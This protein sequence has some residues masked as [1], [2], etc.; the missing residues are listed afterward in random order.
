M[1]LMLIWGSQDGVFGKEAY[2]K[3]ASVVSESLSNIRT[4][5]SLNAETTMSKKYDKQLK[6]SE[7]A[8]VRQSARATSVM[9]LVLAI[10]FVMYGLGFW[11]GAELIAKSTDTALE[12][13][14]S[15]PGLFD[16]SS[17]QYAE[18]RTYI[19]A[20]CAGYSGDALEVCAC[21][22]PYAAL[23]LENPNCGCGFGNGG[24]AKFS[25][26]EGC[27]SGGKTMM[28][29]FAILIGGFSLGQIGPGIKALGDARIAAAKMVAVI[30]RR[31][32]ID[33]E[34]TEGKKRL[35]RGSVAG[36]ITLEDLHFWYAD[37]DG[38]ERRVFGGCNLTIKAGETVALV[39]ESGC[40]KSTI[41]KL[42]QRFYDPTGGRILL[43][44]TD[45]REL[46]LRDLRSSIG[47]VSQE[48]LLF[49][50][51][52]RDNIRCGLPGASD[53]DI[54]AAAKNANAHGFISSFPDGYD[55]PVGPGGN[56]L[57]GGQKQRVAIAR[58]LLRD[59]TILILDE[60]T[61]ALDNKSE[62]IVQQ[63]LDQLVKNNQRQRTTIVIA[64][65][66]STIR[67]ADKIVVVGSPN[68]TSTTSGGSIILEQGTHDDLMAQKGFYKAL[69]GATDR[70]KDAPNDINKMESINLDVKEKENKEIPTKQLTLKKQDK[71]KTKKT[72]AEIAEKQLEKKRAKDNKSR[73]WEYTWPE[74]PLIVL[75]S[76]VSVCKGTTM[77]LLS[78]IMSEMIITWYN[79]DTQEMRNVSKNWSF[80]FYGFAVLTGIFE[81]VQKYVFERVG[82]RLTTKLRS[83]LFRSI[84][85]QD[86]T[87]FEDKANGVGAL[88]S[89]L[90]MDVKLVRLVVGQQ[91]AASLESFS[92]LATGIIIS[93]IATW[94]VFLIMLAMVPLLG[95]TEM[96]QWMALQGSEGNIRNEMMKSTAILHET[97]NGIR[98]VQAFGLES[99]IA[100][101]IKT[102]LFETIGPAS[103]TASV[104]KGTMMGAVQAIQFLVYAFA[105]WFGGE[106]IANGR[107]SFE[108]FTKALWAMAFAASGLGAA[109]TFAGD[110]AK[111][112]AAVKAIFDTLDHDSEIKSE[113]WE[114]RGLADSQSGTAIVRSLPE[115]TLI[116]G[117]SE[118]ASV[119]FCYPTR[120]GAKI[121]DRLSLSIPSG[122]V[123]ALVGS[124]GSGKSTV[125]QLLERF[126]D[127]TSY[128]EEKEDGENKMVV[129]REN[130]VLNVDGVDVKT[131][132]LR[133]LRKN[134]ALVGQEPV[135]FND[136][137]YNNIALG[138][139][140]CTSEEVLTA[141]RRAN[142]HNFIVE[143]Q[144]G[145][146]TIVGNAGGL[147]SGGQKQ[148]IAIARALVN[149]PKILLLDEATSAL[150]NE[151]EKIV[152]A[153][154]D[155]LVKES[156]NGGRTTIIIAHRLST[157]RNADVICVLENNGDGSRV[158]ETGSHNEL[159]M[160]NQKYTALVEA[161]EK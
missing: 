124:S 69:L 6:Q 156:E 71:Q 127:P 109:A 128:K 23:G 43:D 15:P 9:A 101:E 65:R 20:A 83:D 41:A 56:K 12:N 33:A 136:T 144:N 152:Q 54:V 60:A 32:S 81:F 76:F 118:L 38:G 40:G 107:I 103:R 72:E 48:P 102:S 27:F 157:I 142:A 57:S 50:R 24:S 18:H 105:F 66:L 79:P 22:L 77:P 82:E 119:N 17:T 44:G 116:Q 74:M 52:I 151:S 39:G 61:S 55:T 25:T 36:E 99:M 75:G 53:D 148:R 154:L 123:V 4:V 104:L 150:D 3:A 92:A 149:D 73:V 90:S 85:R 10:M 59:P 122:K 137:V 70:S 134:L 94:E 88:S 141:A 62:K 110:A 67:N 158:V 80:Y 8:A 45:L 47:V 86:V 111:A 130:G 42:V 51:S 63:A 160:L 125:I 114:N 113:P 37:K 68:G 95:I 145:F 153:S 115:Q 84:L 138:K 161:Y 132:D 155:N 147:I 120:K 121:F 5:F 14:P 26:S 35:S 143:L 100:R 28:V 133:W 2:E 13:H 64:H 139:A 49:D 87:W 29:F 11:Y 16:A 146:D 96:L 78:L 112:S 89:R 131:M 108:D 117:S 140:N 19:D 46:S 135:L 97:V 106:M 21:G 159:M 1:H 98:E 58:A 31:P 129:E 30:D 34:A 7:G 93:V 91:I 126:Y